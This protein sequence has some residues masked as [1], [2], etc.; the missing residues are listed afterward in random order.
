[1]LNNVAIPDCI[2]MQQAACGRCVHTNVKYQYKLFD[3]RYGHDERIGNGS[4]LES[5]CH[6]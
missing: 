1:M 6:A 4:T 5:R 2:D 3:L